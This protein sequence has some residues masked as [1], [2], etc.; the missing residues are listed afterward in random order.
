MIQPLPAFIV[1]NFCILLSSSSTPGTLHGPG[2][3]DDHDGELEHDDDRRRPRLS[4]AD[5]RHRQVPDHPLRDL[6]RSVDHPEEGSTEDQGAE[7]ARR[8]RVRAQSQERDEA[9]ERK[10][11]DGAALV[12][13]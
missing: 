5:R 13:R 2:S 7:A 11:A 6:H 9:P 12:T 10:V 3:R 8:A 1:V 4:R